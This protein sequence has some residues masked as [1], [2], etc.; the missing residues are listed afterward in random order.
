MAET[1]ESIEL[2]LP[3]KLGYEKLAMAASAM[4]AEG[5]G[6]SQEKV[7]D[8]KTAV[9]EAC[10]NAIEH[11]NKMQVDKKVHVLFGLRESSLIIDVLDEGE[12]N[13]FHV[14]QEPELHQKIEGKKPLRGLGLFLIKRL[15]DEAEFVPRS[16]GTQLRMVIHLKH[17]GA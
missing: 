8:L 6:F 3:S 13:R 9:S 15:T 5:M 16:K 14:S 10:I 4:I 11:G 7:E 17:G 2:R 12:S 1:R